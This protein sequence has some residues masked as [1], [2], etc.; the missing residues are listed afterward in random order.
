M[1]R[2]ITDIPLIGFLLQEYV[3]QQTRLK[4]KERKKKQLKSPQSICK[5][6]KRSERKGLKTVLERANY[7]AQPLNIT[8]WL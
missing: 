8:T 5:S 1:T 4:K 2:I 7:M 3:Q 6:F